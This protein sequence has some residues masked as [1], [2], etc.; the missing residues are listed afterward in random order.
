MLKR[1]M[2]AVHSQPTF[3]TLKF[4]PSPNCSKFSQILLNCILISQIVCLSLVKFLLVI[5]VVISV[6]FSNYF[7]RRLM[8]SEIF[9][10]VFTGRHDGDHKRICLYLTVIR[11]E[12][13]W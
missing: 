11:L 13:P 8:F 4:R 6:L 12:S 9:F 10:V 1:K 3:L 5:V 7:F 2:I